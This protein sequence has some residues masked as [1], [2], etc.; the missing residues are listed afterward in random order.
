M[1]V[2]V[3]KNRMMQERFIVRMKAAY[4]KLMM[5]FTLSLSIIL[6][7]TGGGNSGLSIA[8]LT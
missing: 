4:K 7:G 8:L 1:L 6:T 5:V 2:T 3:I